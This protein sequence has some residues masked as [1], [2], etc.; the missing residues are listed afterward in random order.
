LYRTIIYNYVEKNQASKDKYKK[1]IY[2]R[3]RHTL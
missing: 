3:N 2:Q 1:S